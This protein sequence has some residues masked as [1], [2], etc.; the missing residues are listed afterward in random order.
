L[1]SDITVLLG[2]VPG[3]ADDTAVMRA[4]N[5]FFTVISRNSGDGGGDSSS[6]GSGLFNKITDHNFVVI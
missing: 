1:G 5:A 2:L 6:R 3:L 4:Q